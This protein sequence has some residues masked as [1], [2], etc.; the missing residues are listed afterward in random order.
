MN[1][2]NVTQPQITHVV[3]AMSHL[4]S[5]K[6]APNKMVS[7]ESIEALMTSHVTEFVPVSC[8]LSTL[9]KA[10]SVRYYKMDSGKLVYGFTQ[11]MQNSIFHNEPTPPKREPYMIP[12]STPIDITD[13]D[14]PF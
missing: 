6:G 1:E 2:I 7:V 14:L 4:I 12:G 13:D 8:V 5:E 11:T 3:Q 10:K 9:I